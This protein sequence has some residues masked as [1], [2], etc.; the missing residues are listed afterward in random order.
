M[1]FG[2]T[3]LIF[4]PSGMS[5]DEYFG[6]RDEMTYQEKLLA[7]AVGFSPAG[8]HLKYMDTSHVNLEERRGPSMGSACLIS[9][10]IVAAETA[11]ILLKRNPV[12]AAPHYFHFDPYLHQYKHGYLFFGG[13]NP[14]QK[15]KMMYL[16]YRIAHSNAANSEWCAVKGN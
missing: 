13:R 14:I 1:G 4:T 15:L 9:A 12:M 3:L 5:F 6:I 16:R 2:A 7:F 8:L 11:N 10:G